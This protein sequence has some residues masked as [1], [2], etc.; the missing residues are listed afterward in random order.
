MVE[1]VYY[2]ECFF[3]LQNNYS[4]FRIIFG[5]L[6]SVYFP[7]PVRIFVFFSILNLFVPMYASHDVYY[8]LLYVFP[9]SSS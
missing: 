8:C 7:D 3:V 2:L 9:L 6:F 5:Q 1:M 4:F